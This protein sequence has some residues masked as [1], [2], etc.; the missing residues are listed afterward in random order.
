MRVT[1]NEPFNY[2]LSDDLNTFYDLL[3]LFLF[4]QLHENGWLA[5]KADITPVNIYKWVYEANILR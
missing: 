3:T 2:V 5:E 4:F 1:T